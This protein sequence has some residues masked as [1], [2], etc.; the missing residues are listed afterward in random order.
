MSY[1]HITYLLQ[2]NAK[3]FE[4]A[5]KMLHETFEDLQNQYNVLC[6]QLVTEEDKNVAGKAVVCDFTGK[7]GNWTTMAKLIIEEQLEKGSTIAK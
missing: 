2:K 5:N 4:S 7:I 1:T 6:N 3:L